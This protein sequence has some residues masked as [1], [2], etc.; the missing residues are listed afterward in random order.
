MGKAA[1]RLPGGKLHQSRRTKSICVF[2]ILRIFIALHN[3]VLRLGAADSGKR[4]CCML[5][6]EKLSSRT[7]LACVS[8]SLEALILKFKCFEP[9][10]PPTPASPTV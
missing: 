3:L 2:S 8:S 5:C 7:E 4:A 6:E 10:L 1:Y 9:M